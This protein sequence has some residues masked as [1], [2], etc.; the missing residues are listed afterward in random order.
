MPTDP[1]TPAAQ[2]R[3]LERQVRSIIY[4]VTRRD[5]PAYPQETAL[6]EAVVAW[7][8]ARVEEERSRLR[9]EN[10]RL[11]AEIA[12]VE[13]F[14][15]A[16]LATIR[17]LLGDE[18]SPD[19][20]IAGS[21]CAIILTRDETVRRKKGAE[22]ENA[23][24]REALVGVA[25]GKITS[26]PERDTYCWCELPGIK[27]VGCHESRCNKAR[28]A[29]QAALAER[30]GQHR[31]ALRACAETAAD[32]Q[33]GALAKLALADRLAEHAGYLLRHDS[34]AHRHSLQEALAAY[35]RAGQGEAKE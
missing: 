8:T 5:M 3:A 6:V 31:A 24:L 18:E 12:E 13:R 7:H 29:L 28:A 9:A 2:V 23:R 17:K 27:L 11:S 4:R 33:R 26:G 35:A 16:P 25:L 19:E 34:P 15:A 1:A 32:W 30:E 21:V 14:R 20:A 10:A 22:A